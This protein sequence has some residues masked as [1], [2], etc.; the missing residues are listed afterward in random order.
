MAA[1]YDPY[2]YA[3][4]QPLSEETFT[5]GAALGKNL[6]LKRVAFHHEFLAPGKQSSWAHAHLEEEELVYILKGNPTLYVSGE[7]KLCNEGDFI[8]FRPGTGLTHC[9]R[10]DTQHVCE[11][12]V[13]GEMET[14]NPD[15]IR[16]EREDRNK[17]CRE[18]GIFWDK[19]P[20]INPNFDD[21]VCTFD[22]VPWEDFEGYDTED[23]VGGRVKDFARYMGATKLAFKWV[24]LQGGMRSSYP[25][26]EL[27][28][29]EFCYLI[30]GEATLFFHD[31]EI[32]L[33]PLDAVAFPAGEGIIHSLK[34]KTECSFIFSGE[35]SKL[36]NKYFYPFHQHLK[37]EDDH[38]KYWWDNP[39]TPDPDLFS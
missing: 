20:S 21:I 18:K 19:A 24:E 14:T 10:N 28:E 9:L 12:L 38:Y 17:E 15:L 35:L 7:E 25:H 22:D 37:K 26:A 33:F 2:V 3:Y 29:E 31:R 16:Y 1:F 32:P 13:V 6:G 11:I 23:M 27:L 8:F 36:G 30:N 34:G 5:Y 39:P 4:Y